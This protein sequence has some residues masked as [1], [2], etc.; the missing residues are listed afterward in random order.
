MKRILKILILTFSLTLISGVFLS[1]HHNGNE[2]MDRNEK[3]LLLDAKIKKHPK[4]AELYYE[5]GK[6]Y[7]ELQQVNDA[8]NDFKK[9]ISLD[10]K[11]VEYHTALGDAYFMNGDVGNSYSTLQA[12][13][14]LDP[15]NLEALLKMG[16]ISFYSKDYDR[17]IETLSKVTR[18]DENNRTALYMK[19]FIYKEKED[20]ANAV[21][22]FR[23]VIDLYP[24][25]EPAY[26]ELGMLYASRKSILGEEYLNTALKLE[27]K[28]INARYGLAMLYQ[29]VE[30][31]DQAIDCYVKILEID[32]TNKDAWHNRGYIA[33]VYDHD[34]DSA[35]EFFTKAIDTD[36]Q[37][38]EAHTNR[39]LAYEM[40][41]D[42]T[43]ARNCY[44]TA[45]QINPQFEQAIE[46][47][48][49]VK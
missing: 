4:D 10:N 27:P 34:Y 3:L 49:R 23:K 7:I 41:G 18:L 40:K 6:V 46:G 12:A 20:T 36:N 43:N 2:K 48:K 9:A 45:L 24:D 13:L 33:L 47:L 37:F 39:G 16:E 21:Q 1:C 44:Q 19:A 38:V 11:K 32:P 15:N 29:D 31:Y 5:R 42:K 22:L 26:E 17:A 14:K 8:I 30:M 28:N 25:Y 35:I